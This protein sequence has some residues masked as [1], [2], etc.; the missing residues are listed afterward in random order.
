MRRTIYSK[1]LKGKAEMIVKDIIIRGGDLTPEKA[2]II[3]GD[4][5]EANPYK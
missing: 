1:P 5:E 3:L 4:W 2:L